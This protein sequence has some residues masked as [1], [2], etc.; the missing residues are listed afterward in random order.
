M[1]CSLGHWLSLYGGLW[2]D[3]ALPQLELRTMTSDLTDEAVLPDDVPNAKKQNLTF[4]AKL[5]GAWVAMGFRNPKMPVAVEI[6]V[7]DLA[8]NP[9]D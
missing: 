4:F 8:S 5:I 6:T 7:P 3:G 9:G 2:P 1:V